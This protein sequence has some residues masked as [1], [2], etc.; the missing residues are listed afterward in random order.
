MEQWEKEYIDAVVKSKQAMGQGKTIHHSYEE[1]YDSSRWIEMEKPDGTKYY[2]PKEKAFDHQKQRTRK[3]LRIII[4]IKWKSLLKGMAVIFLG[5]V[6]LGNYLSNSGTQKKHI[7]EWRQEIRP[8]SL[9][10]F[11]QGKVLGGTYINGYGF[12]DM[13]HFFEEMQTERHSFLNDVA[14]NIDSLSEIDLEWWSQ[15]MDERE[16]LLAKLKYADSYSQYVDAEKQVFEQQK[17]LLTLVKYNAEV[18]TVLEMYYQLS[19][20]DVSLR[21]KAVEAMKKNEIDYT[22]NENGLRYWYKQY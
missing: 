10:G 21:N 2:V 13:M 19:G 22:V 6:L 5:F 7:A 4:R 14:K 8:V 17:V 9:Q 16:E 3:T 18:H 20:A 15:I 12:A 1:G 11:I